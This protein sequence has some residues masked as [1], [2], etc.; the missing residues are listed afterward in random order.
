ML[1]QLRLSVG[2]TWRFTRADGGVTAELDLTSYRGYVSDLKKG[3]AE[4]PLALPW[5]DYPST[6]WR[7]MFGGPY[8]S[9]A[10]RTLVSAL[11]PSRHT[12]A[13]ADQPAELVRP[14]EVEILWHPF[15]VAAMLHLDVA[16]AELQDENAAAAHLDRLLNLPLDGPNRRVR[17]G[18]PFDHVPERPSVDADGNEATYV[19]SG[20]FRLLSGLHDASDPKR[21][22]AGLALLFQAMSDDAQPLR[23]TRGA[24]SVRGGTVGMVLPAGAYRAEAHVRCLH[25]NQALLLA[26]MENLAALLTDQ[27]AAVVK[28]YRELAGVVLNCLHRRAALKGTGSIYKAR[29]AEM[30]IK[31]RQLAPRINDATAGLEDAPPPLPV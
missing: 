22:A 3:A 21:V 29:V 9:V 15:A 2:T 27:G 30:W 23:D 14:P 8:D 26:Q 24:V 7:A 28:R 4:A 6:F 25:H 18:A 10:D 31:H 17:D 13:L 20:D 1:H 11:V 5:P 16:D 12:V 19:H